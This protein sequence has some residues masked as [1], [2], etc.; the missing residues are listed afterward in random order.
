MLSHF[1]YLQCALAFIAFWFISTNSSQKAWKLK[2]KTQCTR[3]SCPE[4]QPTCVKVTLWS[5]SQIICQ[6]ICKMW[7]LNN[8]HVSIKHSRSFD[9]KQFAGLLD[10]FCSLDFSSRYK[11]NL[12]LQFQYWNKKIAW[13]H[14]LGVISERTKLRFMPVINLIL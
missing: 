5:C 10:L 1:R 2:S 4:P 12:C 7:L 6:G 11:P 13:S 9:E 14:G 8:L 3:F